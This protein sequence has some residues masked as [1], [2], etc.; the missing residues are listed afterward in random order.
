MVLKAL[1]GLKTLR[2]FKI[3]YYKFHVSLKFLYRYRLR[4]GGGGVEGSDDLLLTLELTQA[5][6]S[7][8]N[9][10]NPIRTC[11]LNASR[12]P[13]PPYRTYVSQVRM[14]TY[15]SQVRISR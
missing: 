15:V 9:V 1:C 13:G 2:V 11:E 3:A 14:D 12:D 8:V 4:C 10:L 6:L 5:I 7:V